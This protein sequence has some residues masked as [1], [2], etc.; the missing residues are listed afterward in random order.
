MCCQFYKYNVWRIEY[1]RR[2]WKLK[3]KILEKFLSIVLK[4]TKIFI[5]ISFSASF[6]FPEIIDLENKSHFST[7]MLI[8]AINLNHI[9]FL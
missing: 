5:L 8:I 4:I 3:K 9:F 2:L 7:K 1:H 6:V